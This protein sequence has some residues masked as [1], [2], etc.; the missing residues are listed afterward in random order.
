MTITS[1]ALM[2]FFFNGCKSCFFFV[3]HARRAAKI[4]QGY[5]RLLY[6]AAFRSE[7][8]FEDDEAAGRLERRIE[9]AHNL[10]RRRFLGRGCFSARVRPVTVRQSPRSSPASRRRFATSAVPPAA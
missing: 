5:G 10:L 4:L 3:E 8:S 9:F 2:T 7:I 6:N 1:P